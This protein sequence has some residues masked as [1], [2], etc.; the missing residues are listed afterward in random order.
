MP[1]EIHRLGRGLGP[2][3]RLEVG[4][5][6]WGAEQAAGSGGRG[7]RGSSGTPSGFALLDVSAATSVMEL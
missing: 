5:L 4:P 6:S 1:E 2:A 3:L 7:P